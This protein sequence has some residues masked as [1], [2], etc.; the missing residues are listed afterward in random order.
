MDLYYFYNANSRH[1]YLRVAFGTKEGSLQRQLRLIDLLRFQTF[2]ESLLRLSSGRGRQ[3]GDISHRTESVSGH[4]LNQQ[5]P[6]PQD[7]C[8]M[9]AA[10]DLA[11]S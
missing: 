6:W 4:H 8:H 9:F 3:S 7:I 1:C 11:P 2:D 10:A 5:E